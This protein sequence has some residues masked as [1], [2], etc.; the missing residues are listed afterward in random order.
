MINRILLSILCMLFVGVTLSHAQYT[1]PPDYRTFYQ[2]NAPQQ[3]FWK[4]Y[5]PKTTQ[6]SV[7]GGFVV[8]DFWANYKP[9]SGTSAQGTNAGT[10]ATYQNNNQ[11][12]NGSSSN[13]STGNTTV[14]R[15]YWEPCQFCHGSGRC[16]TCNGTGSMWLG[17][18][19]TGKSPCPN[20]DNNH[21]G[22]CHHCHGAKGRN[23]T[24]TN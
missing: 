1:P 17:L 4:N 20:C 18:G 19:S 3:D 5:K 7:V 24:I 23:V 22:V 12:N 14:S 21:N 15:T 9:G 13:Q 10:G 8:E 16:S 2:Q 11:S 6:N